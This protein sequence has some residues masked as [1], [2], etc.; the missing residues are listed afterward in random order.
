MA[1]EREPAPLHRHC[2]L[3]ATRRCVSCPSGYYGNEN[4]LVNIVRALSARRLS[5]LNP[6]C[7]RYWE[8]WGSVQCKTERA[9]TTEQSIGACN[10]NFFAHECEVSSEIPAL[11]W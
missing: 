9:P 2:L 4:N 10:A 8:S 11:F 3:A 7:D 1:L 5:K 6:M